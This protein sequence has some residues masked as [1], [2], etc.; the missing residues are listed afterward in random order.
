ME[1]DKVSCL[2]TFDSQIHCPVD[3]VMQRY[4]GK[5]KQKQKSRPGWA[6]WHMPLIQGT[7]DTINWKL[8]WD[9]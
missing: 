1:V 6:W 7:L 9:I 8:A 4:H 5:T 3:T 2:R